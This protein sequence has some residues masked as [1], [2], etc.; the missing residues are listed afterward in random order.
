MWPERPSTQSPSVKGKKD[1]RRKLDFHFFLLSS[2]GCNIVPHTDNSHL[3]PFS[4]NKFQFMSPSEEKN[5]SF[6]DMMIKTAFGIFL[7]KFVVVHHAKSSLR[8]QCV[9]NM[10][11]WF[12]DRKFLAPTFLLNH[13]KRFSIWNY[14]RISDSSHHKRGEAT[15]NFPDGFKLF[16][17]KGFQLLS[18]SLE[19]LWKMSVLHGK[20]NLTSGRVCIV[21]PDDAGKRFTGTLKVGAKNRAR[22]REKLPLPLRSAETS[23]YPNVTLTQLLSP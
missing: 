17:K 18:V 19:L 9:L 1:G 3:F 8:H 14:F 13:L 4:R 15:K 6:S 21:F 23:W 20:R 10:W 7:S 5:F 11:R 2:P 22:N 12:S 16:C